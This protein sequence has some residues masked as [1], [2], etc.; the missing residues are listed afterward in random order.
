LYDKALASVNA[1]RRGNQSSFIFR[2]ASV[3]SSRNLG[4][5]M[6][7]RATCALLGGLAAQL[8]HA[9]FGDHVVDIVL[10]GR[11]VGARAQ[12]RGNA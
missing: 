12:H 4:C 5:A 3:S 6:P 9:V 2:A 8:C 10:A 7:I 1:H 11:N